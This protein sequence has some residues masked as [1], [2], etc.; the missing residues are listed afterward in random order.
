MIQ[1]AVVLKRSNRI[2]LAIYLVALLGLLMFPFGGLGFRILGIGFDK[3]MHVAMFAGLA[4]LLRWNLSASRYTTFA[5]IVTASMVAAATEVAQG[6]VSYRSAD[7]WDLVAGILGA[8]LGAVIMN[9][10]LASRVADRSVGLV[11]VVLGLMVGASFGLADVIGISSNN[12][13]GATQI[14]GTALGA[15]IAIGGIG[16]FITGLRANH[17]E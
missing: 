7:L 1:A 10:I 15:L 14:A 17:S 11:V 2:L 4:A 12:T 3:L 13:F 6:F 5:V 16:I 8:A 9:R